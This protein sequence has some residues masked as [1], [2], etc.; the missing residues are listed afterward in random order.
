M[1][2]SKQTVLAVAVA[3]GAGDA[4]H[5]QAP[6]SLLPVKPG[7]W[8]D[9][10]QSCAA[11]ASA[12]IFDGRRAGTVF[13][14]VNPRM[15]REPQGEL[16][17]ITG[18]RRLRSGFTE[19]K[20]PSLGELAYRLIKPQG[21]ERATLILAAPSNR[22]GMQDHQEDLRLCSYTSLSPRMQLALRR[23]AP[24]LAP[25][26]SS[27]ATGPAIQAHSARPQPFAVQAAP[28]AAVTSLPP[29]GIAAG[30]YVDERTPCTDPISAFYYDGRRAGVIFAQGGMRP[31]PIGRPRREGGEHFLP[32]AG[33]LVKVLGPARIR[34]TIQDVG[35]PM[36]L[37]PSSQIPSSIRRLAL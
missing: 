18:V 4:A 2:L 25:A 28:P 15:G 14:Y 8:V 30:F 33:L 24:T 20:H 34:L 36:R 16:E 5:P 17:A 6:A 7:V 31:D 21:P 22:H 29:L 32:N 3:V 1:P 23:F 27:Q 11:A 26:G 10:R 9:E 37:C 19:F 12:W 35:E 13:Y